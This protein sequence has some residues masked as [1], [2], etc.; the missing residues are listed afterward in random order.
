MKRKQ[1][2]AL[3]LVC[4]AL[5]GCGGDSDQKNVISQRYIHKYGYDVSRTEWDKEVHPGQ[6][7]TMLRDGKSIAATYEDGVLHGPKT[8]TH[9]HSQTTETLEQYERGK[10]VKRVTYS[11][12]GVPQKEEVFLSPSH[13]LITSWYPS[14]TPKYKE[15]I[16]DGILVNG[17]YFNTA[18]ET[19]TRIDNG[20]GEKTLR[21]QNGD[22]L[23]KEVYNNYAVT[24][25][26]TYYPNN[27]P[28]TSTSYDNGTIHGEQR[29]YTING[30]P[31]SVEN[32]FYGNRHG[33]CTYYQ[34][35]YKFKE[36]NYTHGLK[37][38]VERHYID[39]EM[40]VEETL[41]QE[42]IKHGPSIVYYDNAAKTTWYFL[43]EKVSK[44]KYDQLV[45]RENMIMS[46]QSSR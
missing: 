1:E 37:D 21:N 38:G 36:V 26:E 6:V 40:V 25:V 45:A 32:F 16:K 11:L 34:N 42:G 19:D 10:L 3:S 14:G 35:G 17:Q 13:I 46:M 31:N 29:I 9:A 44:N 2:L 30:E 43:D 20:T 27:I 24:Y 22:I 28:H 18:N 23:S 7:L 8:Q 4:L 39:G 5:Y 12:R 15:E 41:Y 33:L